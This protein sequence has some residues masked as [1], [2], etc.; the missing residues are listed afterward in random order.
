MGE[1]IAFQTTES[2]LLRG[3]L[4][5]EAK[6]R[7][8]CRDRSSSGKVSCHESTMLNRSMSAPRARSACWVSSGVGSTEFVYGVVNL[9]DDEVVTFLTHRLRPARVAR[10]DQ[11]AEA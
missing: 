2:L 10:V 11:Y 7:E 9:R 3:H 1:D 4:R 8:P 5:H 6:R